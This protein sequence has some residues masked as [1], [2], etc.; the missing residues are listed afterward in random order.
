M[1]TFSNLVLDT[2]GNYT[3]SVSDGALPAVTTGSITISPAL[4]SQLVLQQSPTSGTA[5]QSLDALQV[6]V[7]DGFGNVITG[8][9]STVTVAVATGPAGFATGSTTSATVVSGIA[10]FSNLVF[11]TAGNYTLSLSDTG[12]TGITTGSITIGPTSASQLVL[13]QSPTGGTAGQALGTI[14]F[15][16]EDTFGNVVTGDSSTVMISVATGP[17]G[18]A[19][20]ST[21][22]AAAV[23]G[24]ATFSNLLFNTAGSYTLSVGDGSLTGATTG[25]ITISPATASQLMLQQ[26][27]TGGTAG[28]ALAALEVAVEDVFGNVIASDNSTVTVAVATGPGGFAVGSTTSVAAGDGVATLS[29]LTL[30]TAGAYTLTVTDGTLTSATSGNVVVSPA[31]ASQLAFQQTPTTGVTGQPLSPAVTVAVED[32]FGNVVTSDTSSVT[33]AAASGPGGFATG[34]TTTV[35]AASG[36]ATFSNLMLNTAG[37]YTLSVTDGALSGV[38]SSTII[39]GVSPPVIT[40]PAT[41]LVN[42]NGSLV[43]S[44]SN[45]NALSFVD[46]GAGSNADLLTMTVAQGTLTLG[47]TNGLI[48]SSGSNDSASFTIKGTVNNLNAALSRVTYQPNANYAG[49]DSLAISVSDPGDGKL[50]SASVALTVSPGVPAITAPAT[51]VLSENGSLVFS[52]GNGNAISF[53]D[54]GPGADSLT[55]TVTHGALTLATTTG[56]TLTGSNGSASFTLTGSVANLNAALNGLTYQPTTRFSGS[57]S[58]AVSL[59]DAGDSLSTS[60]S[61]ALTING[62]APV[63]RGSGHGLRGP[64]RV[65]GLFVGQWQCDLGLRCGG[66]RWLRLAHARCLERNA[67]ALHHDGIDVYGRRQRLVFLHGQRNGDESQ[68]GP[69]RPHLSADLRLF[70]SRLADDFDR[71][72]GGQRIGVEQRCTHRQRANDHSSRFGRSRHEW[73]AGFLRGEWKRHHGGRL[74]PGSQLRFGN[75]VGFV[76]NAD[77]LHHGRIDDYGGHKRLVL[78]HRERIRGQSQRGPQ[79]ADL[80]ADVRVQGVR[81]A[82]HIA[83][84]LGRWPLGFRERGPQQSPRDHGSHDGDRASQ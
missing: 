46:N 62:L 11:D 80:S 82:G 65:A 68:P 77:A 40:A 54:A 48:F 56:L 36:L 33:I 15:S 49:S 60:K 69:E 53:V 27:P 47:S 66:R 21:T 1:A 18:F 8:D 29:N 72:P 83:Q 44:A 14:K 67:D 20:G 58:L 12:L 13:Q 22:S 59:T 25:S 71:G 76:R 52:S 4:A 35:S 7:E 61:V 57:D 17:A 84:R 73:H 51:A 74:Q 3:L 9:T 75:P 43:F 37:N 16:V 31:T 63:D 39:V 2:A 38:T 23:G 78:D 45:G 64:E 55:L 24:V 26:S 32:A 79:R 6:A 50:G 30:D 5:G 70:G 41:A 34:S 81:F 10:T 42:E 19:A 28:R